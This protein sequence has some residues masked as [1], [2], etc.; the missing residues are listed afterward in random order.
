MKMWIRKRLDISTKDL[1]YGLMHCFTTGFRTSVSDKIQK[2]WDNDNQ[3]CFICLSVRT[4]F[5]L[6]FQAL[7]FEAGGEVLMS[8]LTITDMPR[9]IEAHGL[10]PIPIDLNT[11]NLGPTLDKLEAAITHKTKAIVVAH[12]FGG[13]VDLD[14]IVEIAKRHNILVIEDCAQAYYSKTYSGNANAD[15]SMFSFGTIKTATALGGAILVFRRNELLV[16]KI[17]KLH[18]SYPI[19]IRQEFIK[20]TLKYLLIN[21]LSSPQIFPLVIKL[22]TR[23]SIDYDAY[24]HTLSK[25]FP[26]GNFFEKIRHQPSYP[27]LKLLLYRIETYNFYTIEARIERGNYLLSNLPKSFTFPGQQAIFQTYWAFPIITDE[28]QKVIESLRKNGFDATNKNSLSIVG[29][30]DNN[31]SAALQNIQSIKNKIVFLP[32]YA[33]IPMSELTK[34]AKCL[35]KF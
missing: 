12:L 18:S 30:T 28:S 25:S 23:K 27:L 4:G 24:I 9:I 13:I 19:Q 5:D 22:L 14:K 26:N 32:L 29:V 35:Q 17:R 2:I 11:N 7:K 20:K 1:I 34:M 6:L 10:K 8:A 31:T 15:V 33:E 21:F 3:T 16:N